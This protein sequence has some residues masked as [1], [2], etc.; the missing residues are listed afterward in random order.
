MK[1][2]WFSALLLAVVVS[3]T[4]GCGL[5]VPTDPDGT[6]DRVTGGELRVGASPHGGLVQV[7][8]ASVSGTEADLV[9]DY[10]ASIGSAVQ[11]TTG[12]EESLVGALT[13]GDL[14][15]VVGGI[16]DQTPWADRVAVTRGFPNP[17]NPHGEN[18]VWLAPLGENRFVSSL[19]AFLD[20]ART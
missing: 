12:G 13:H 6:L 20:G 1:L 10:A 14:D 18:L 9:Q 15:L 16:T 3:A 5:Q 4:A 8:G 11:W 7:S 2:R 17:E 19:E